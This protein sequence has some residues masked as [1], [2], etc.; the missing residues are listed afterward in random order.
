MDTPESFSRYKLTIWMKCTLWTHVIQ[1]LLNGHR[2]LVA[3]CD[4][5][6]L[7]GWWVCL[8]EW[9]GAKTSVQQFHTSCGGLAN[10]IATKEQFD[11][12]VV[13]KPRFLWWC[14]TEVIQWILCSSGPQ[15]AD[16]LCGC[17]NRHQ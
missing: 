10:L 15:L 6:G 13:T 8:N 14:W 3:V 5:I 17:S 2:L 11:L 1:L 4:Q 16:V 12:A 9:M 7:N